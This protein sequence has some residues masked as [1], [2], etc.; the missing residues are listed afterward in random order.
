MATSPCITTD[1]RVGWALSQASTCLRILSEPRLRAAPARIFCLS[2]GLPSALIERY[3]G[4]S[5]A[6]SHAVSPLISASIQ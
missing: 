4:S 2:A 6:S 1:L 5:I 3:S